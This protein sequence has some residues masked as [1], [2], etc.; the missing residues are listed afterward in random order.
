M[1][2][3]VLK[4]IPLR[5][6]N[7]FSGWAPVLHQIIL[8]VLLFQFAL[9]WTRFWVRIPWI[10][11]GSWP[12]GVLLVLCVASTLVSL[13]RQLPGQNVLM[14]A[15]VIATCAGA[16]QVLGALTYI[17]FGPY[18]YDKRFGPFLFDVLPW[19]VPLIWIVALLNARGVA[20]L[21]LRPW[22]HNPVYGLW[23]IG[24]TVGLI[25][26]LDLGLEPFATQ[27]M[28]YWSWRPTRVPSD[29]YSTPW[30][31]FLGW[32]VTSLLILAFVTPVLINKKPVPRLPQYHPVLMWLLL[33]LMFTTGAARHRLWLVVELGC[34]L[35]ILVTILALWGAKHE[36]LNR[37]KA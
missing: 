25:I 27:V 28:G 10:P 24:M 5:R 12:E 32:C 8:G 30:V 14:A 29:W 1:D 2:R 33:N 16:A 31:N 37:P 9:V 20:R 23:L 11:R 13:S 34:A 3:V 26:F 19:P 21:I 22:R 6:P 18:V 4:H 35:T 17:P 36:G 15:V 7:R